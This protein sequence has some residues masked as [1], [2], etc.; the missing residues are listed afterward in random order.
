MNGQIAAL[1]EAPSRS[2]QHNNPYDTLYWFFLKRPFSD[3]LRFSDITDDAV[4]SFQF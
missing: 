2:L 1:F 4:T 3:E